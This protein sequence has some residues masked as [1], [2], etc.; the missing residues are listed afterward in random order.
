MR[1]SLLPAYPRR[2][3]PTPILPVL[4]LGL[5][6]RLPHLYTYATPGA[7]PYFHVLTPHPLGA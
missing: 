2:P 1:K 4:L 3:C 7:L 6:A 5:A